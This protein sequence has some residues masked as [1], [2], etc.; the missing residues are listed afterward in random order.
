VQCIVGRY[1]RGADSVVN[2]VNDPTLQMSLRA[3][4]DANAGV[5]SSV[6]NDYDAGSG[7]LSDLSV[8]LATLDSQLSA[9]NALSEEIISNVSLGLKAAR[10]QN[11]NAQGPVV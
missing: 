7:G 11:S 2:A 6:K 10:Q 4:V 5:L 8:Q 1:V 3:I 9:V